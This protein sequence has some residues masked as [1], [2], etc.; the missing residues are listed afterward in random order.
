MQ[1]TK[2]QRVVSSKWIAMFIYCVG[3]ILSEVGYCLI[4]PLNGSL[5]LLLFKDIN[6]PGRKHTQSLKKL[7][8]CA[9]YILRV[10]ALQTIYRRGPKEFCDSYYFAHITHYCSDLLP[11]KSPKYLRWFLG[12]EVRSNEFSSEAVLRRY[13]RISDRPR[14]NI[15]SQQMEKH[16]F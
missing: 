16:S 8:Y 11:F 4:V 5:S 13:M 10:S 1:T 6:C 12:K 3:T 7:L 14:W 15:S 9:W 2:R